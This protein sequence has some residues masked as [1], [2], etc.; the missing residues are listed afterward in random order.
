MSSVT[1]EQPT[2]IPHSRINGYFAGNSQSRCHQPGKGN[3]IPAVLPEPA[4]ANRGEELG[5]VYH[6]SVGTHRV[7]REPEP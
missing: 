4:S 2:F 5:L 7:Q 3:A 1:S 6:Q